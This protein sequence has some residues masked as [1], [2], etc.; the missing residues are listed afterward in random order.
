MK[1]RKLWRVIPVMAFSVGVM[2]GCGS[3]KSGNNNY[4]PPMNPIA[5]GGPTNPNSPTGTAL[6]WGNQFN[7]TSASTYRT[8][9]REFG[10]V[11]DP[12]SWINIGSISCENWDSRAYLEFGLMGATIHDTQGVTGF[13]RVYAYPE[14]SYNPYSPGY[15]IQIQG[16]YVWINGKTAYELRTTGMGGTQSYNAVLRVVVQGQPTD[17]TV[18]VELHYRNTLMGWGNMFRY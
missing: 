9:L 11:C 10:V 14:Y 5:P 8:F 3:E 4:I 6:M 2:M 7:I 17:N 18:R 13:A 12:Y 16:T 15:P 1:S